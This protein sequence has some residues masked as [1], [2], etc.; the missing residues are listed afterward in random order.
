VQLSGSAALRA[1]I[2]LLLR[3]VV[4]EIVLL[5]QPHTHL[6]AL[7]YPCERLWLPLLLRQ[8]LPACSATAVLCFLGAC[9]SCSLARY[10][11]V[12]V[13]GVLCDGTALWSNSR[14]GC[15]PGCLAAACRQQQASSSA[16]SIGTLLLSYKFC[17]KWDG[18]PETLHRPAVAATAACCCSGGTAPVISRRV[19]C[20]YGPCRRN[21]A[22]D[23]LASVKF[24]GGRL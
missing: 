22:S 12:A 16:Q 7:H 14:A 4:H 17:N 11:T 9:G 15:L 10:S 2:P 21:L 8:I 23:T 5:H 13:L 1:C 24:W 6:V 18:L 20:F 19:C 3:P